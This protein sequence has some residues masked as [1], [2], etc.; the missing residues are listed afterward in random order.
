MDHT[1]NS[2]NKHINTV[3]LELM[4]SQVKPKASYLH[5]FS[6]E[7]CFQSESYFNNIK[8]KN[9]YASS[10]QRGPMPACFGFDEESKS[11]TCSHKQSFLKDQ[12]AHSHSLHLYST[13]SQLL[14]VL[15]WPAAKATLR[16]SQTFNQL[17]Q[18]P[19]TFSVSS[20]NSTSQRRGCIDFFF[21]FSQVN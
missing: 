20:L 12:T 3:D 6:H 15:C 13:T 5:L 16:R 14:E 17:L 8:K 9:E 1:V 11:A 19:L 2:F 21:F 18:R 7:S 4:T 10:P